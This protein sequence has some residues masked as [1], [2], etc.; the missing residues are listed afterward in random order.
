MGVEVLGFVEA[1]FLGMYH[2]VE[3]VQGLII[4]EKR[5]VGWRLFHPMGREMNDENRYC[6]HHSQQDT[7][8]LLLFRQRRL[9]LVFR[10]ILMVF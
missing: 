1:I 4:H 10:H 2:A 7:P 9:W 6:H 3:R 5:R 8:R